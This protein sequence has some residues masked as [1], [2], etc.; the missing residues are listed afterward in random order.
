MH[1]GT[2]LSGA[3][4]RVSAAGRYAWGVTPSLLAWAA[5][6]LP[7]PLSNGGLVGGLVL[8]YVVD[9]RYLALGALPSWYGRL[10]TP[11]TA[12]ATLSLASWLVPGAMEAAEPAPPK[13]P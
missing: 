10:R 8:A 3:S 12:A 5:L 13:K 2:A 1:W 9:R 7:P 11:L 4:P 6:M